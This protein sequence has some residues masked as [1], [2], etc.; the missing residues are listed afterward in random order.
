MLLILGQ[1]TLLQNSLFHHFPASADLLASWFRASVHNHPATWV[2]HKISPQIRVIHFDKKTRIYIYM[3]T[4][5][6]MCLLY[7]YIYINVCDMCIITVG[8]SCCFI[9]KKGWENLLCW[10]PK[11]HFDWYQVP[12]RYHFEAIG[13]RFPIFGIWNHT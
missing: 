1:L 9:K 13:F 10:A 7:I 12:S 4:C 2:T 11:L 5:I 8:V 3:Q 6:Y